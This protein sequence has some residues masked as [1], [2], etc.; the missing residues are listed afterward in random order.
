MGLCTWIV[1][2]ISHAL[3]E[4]LQYLLCHRLDRVL[5]GFSLTTCKR[6]CEVEQVTASASLHA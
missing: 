3:Q 4:L 6:W 1:I 2:V 5:L